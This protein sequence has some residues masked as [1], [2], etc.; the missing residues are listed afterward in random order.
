MEM[1]LLFEM[2]CFI[3]DLWDEVVVD[4]AVKKTELAKVAPSL[5][6]QLMIARS[7]SPQQL[8]KYIMSDVNDSA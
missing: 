3:T 8:P 6:F 4:A 7:S 2:L 1:L 5:S